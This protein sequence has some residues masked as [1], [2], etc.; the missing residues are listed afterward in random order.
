MNAIKFKH[1]T[2]V[3]Y[4]LKD[5]D[6]TIDGPLPR[7]EEIDDA[8]L[9]GITKITKR[10]LTAAETNDWD[11]M[12]ECLESPDREIIKKSIDHEKRATATRI[13]AEYGHLNIVR[14]IVEGNLMGPSYHDDL[15][16]IAVVAATHGHLPVVKYIFKR[17]DFLYETF[18][19]SGFPRL[20]FD[21]R[22]GI[23]IFGAVTNGHLHVVEFLCRYVPEDILK[24]VAMDCTR[25]SVLHY[26]HMNG[27][28]NVQ[29][30]IGAYD[31]RTYLSR[32]AQKGNLKVV[33]WLVMDMKVDA[34]VP[35]A[36]GVTPLMAAFDDDGL[37]DY[38]YE[39]D[40]PKHLRTAY[41]LME[42]GGVN[43]NDV[44]DEETGQTA[45][46]VACEMFLFPVIENILKHTKVDLT[47]VDAAG[48]S[49]WDMV[50]WRWRGDNDYNDYVRSHFEPII[51]IMILESEDIPESFL[52]RYP[53]DARSQAFIDKQFILRERTQSYE[54]QRK[55]ALKLQLSTSTKK[56]PE[57]IP[58]DVIRNI[59]SFD[60]LTF[61]EKYYYRKRRL[62][63]EDE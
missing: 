5:T 54:K 8:W 9:L 55:R 38:S 12:F 10:Y 39:G 15:Y 61:D 47:V 25:I 14:N 49:V 27:H 60:K 6:A 17:H 29:S 32:A 26:L 62:E 30:D 56:R 20:D 31:K 53:H 16:S 52:L 57:G 13:A 23:A 7:D 4:L 24:F 43:V 21:A 18:T 51:K 48:D 50:D 33:E 35:D 42:N 46:M 45:I 22:Q 1:W 41:W 44:V 63:E 37:H 40:R 19:F 58:R 28:I 2:I 36:D 34:R 3:E 11:T 59:K